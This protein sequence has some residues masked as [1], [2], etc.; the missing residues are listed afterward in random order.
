MYER[1]GNRWI[2]YAKQLDSYAYS[3]G[4]P[5]FE[6]VIP[7]GIDQHDEF[8]DLVPGMVGEATVDSAGDTNIKSIILDSM[9]SITVP[10]DLQMTG[11]FK[12]NRSWPAFMEVTVDAQTNLFFKK[13]DFTIDVS[14]ILD[15]AVI[16][17]IHYMINNDRMRKVVIF[18]YG[19]IKPAI[20]LPKVSA[21]VSFQIF[22]NRT[23]ASTLGITANA[24]LRM[25]ASFLS[26]NIPQPAHIKRKTK[27]SLPAVVAKLAPPCY[28]WEALMEVA[29]SQ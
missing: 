20:R 29:G 25:S 16:S 4:H 24:D 19:L 13:A 14:Q 7:V 22:G 21:T 23:D 3:Y 18:A 28:P 15:S 8:S 27:R 9:E 12:N 17:A 1:R 11:D 5:G 6:E 10:I 2:D 26:L